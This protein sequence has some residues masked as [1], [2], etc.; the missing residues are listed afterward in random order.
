MTEQA[1]QVDVIKGQLKQCLDQ[2]LQIHGYEITPHGKFLCPNP[3][4]SDSTP[5]AG[6]VP[7]TNGEVW[8]CHG[9]GTSGDIFHIAYW[10][11]GL[12]T[13][14]KEFLTITLPELAKR[15]RIPY[16]PPDLTDHDIYVMGLYR[17][18]QDAATIL[19]EFS[20]NQIYTAKQY[21]WAPEVCHAFSIG[22]V[23]SWEDFKSR[24]T[25]RHKHSTKDIEDAG[26][27][28]RLFNENCITFTIRDEW[29][30]PCGF[31]ARDMRFGTVPNINKYYNTEAKIPIYRKGSLLYGFDKARFTRGPLYIVEGYSDVV[32]PWSHGIQNVSAVCST[33]LT[34]EH[35]ELLRRHRKGDIIMMFDWDANGAGAEAVTN[36]IDK[37]LSGKSG[38]RVRVGSIGDWRAYG[39]ADL[40]SFDPDA[41]CKYVP[42]PKDTWYTIPAIDAFEWRLKQFDPNTPI[43]EIV[44]KVIPLVVNESSNTQRDIM[45]QQLSTATGIRLK[46][47]QR[48]LDV[49]VREEDRAY[50]D[51]IQKLKDNLTKKARNAEPSEFASLITSTAEQLD[52]LKRD[53]FIS[54]EHSAED[55]VEFIDKFVGKLNTRQEGLVGWTTGMPMFDDKFSGIPKGGAFMAIAGNPNVGKTSL[56]DF[57]AW[58]VLTRND[59][60]IVL[61]HTIDDA[62][63]QC[64][65]KLAS[66]DCQQP[67]NKI[68]QPIYMNAQEKAAVTQSWARV[69]YYVAH[70]RL[71]IK[72]AVQGNTLSFAEKWIQSIREEDPDTPIFYILDNFH[73]LQG[74]GADERIKYKTASAKLHLMK[75]QYNLSALCTMELRK[76]DRRYAPGVSDLSE[77]NQMIYDADA[78]MMMRNFQKDTHVTDVRV[79]EGMKWEKIRADGSRAY[80]P[81]VAL[82]IE[83]DKIYGASG[84]IW[85]EFD[86]ECAFFREIDP[87]KAPDPKQLGSKV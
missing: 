61:I 79:K 35:I 5:S 43:R 29:G 37:T 84:R 1:N 67:L 69:K 68:K 72:D 66:T 6:I 9:C 78:V 30:R 87:K 33:A 38:I 4:H 10:Q 14:G 11:E 42:N 15:F 12:P 40:T 47:I 25:L 48:D 39:P 41:F 17:L 85:Y 50:Q 53:E 59:D 70:G 7:D 21:G 32:T 52:E 80:M 54:T 28:K 22:T 75:I 62:K 57:I 26:I 18:Y 44:D 31:A 63:G 82:D 58:N 86:A 19:S 13:S 56:V 55:T 46:A 3:G 73:K 34:E 24:L 36:H 81:Y 83:K 76:T 64:I 51:K 49:L 8:H 20:T 77:S 27:L 2:Y 60:A 16:E 65:L 74:Y 71:D 45:C 23:T